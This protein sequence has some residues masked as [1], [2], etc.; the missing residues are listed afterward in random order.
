MGKKWTPKQKALQSAKMK[1][2]W[3]AKKSA[4]PVLGHVPTA[5]T[6]SIVQEPVPELEPKSG[7]VS[8]KQVQQE[9][10][11]EEAELERAYKA[12]VKDKSFAGTLA[13]FQMQEFLEHSET[14][15]MAF[16]SYLRKLQQGNPLI[17]KDFNDRVLGKP[18]QRV[19]VSADVTSKNLLSTLSP[20]QVLKLAKRQPIVEQPVE[21]ST[22]QPSSQPFSQPAQQHEQ[23]APAQNYPYKPFPPVL[24]Q[25]P[26]QQVILPTLETPSTQPS[27]QT[28][29]HINVQQAPVKDAAS[30]PDSNYPGT[31]PGFDPKKWG[32]G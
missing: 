1:A 17:L 15:N 28:G 9:A 10:L 14:V 16:K 31:S 6:S 23:A 26:T 7:L 30:S 21:Q 11:D 25:S 2:H 4:Q 5:I 19:E 3:E 24:D 12:V 20:D 22:V 32:T 18:T 8:L 13:K 27:T 29:A